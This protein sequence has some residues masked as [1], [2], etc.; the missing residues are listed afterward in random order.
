MSQSPKLNIINNFLWISRLWNWAGR[1]Q[2][3][4]ARSPLR[5]ETQAQPTRQSHLC[6]LTRASYQQT[7]LVLYFSNWN[8]ELHPFALFKHIYVCMYVKIIYTQISCTYIHIY[9]FLN[10][11]LMA[12]PFLACVF[13]HL[14][15]NSWPLSC[16]LYF[17]TNFKKEKK[18]TGKI[19]LLMKDSKSLQPAWVFFPFLYWVQFLAVGLP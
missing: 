10:F 2:V 5:S 12:V 15:R 19:P 7:L 4:S 8:Y 13:T 17:E 14:S 9:F 11:I 3:D 18:N 1:E 16:S 6:R